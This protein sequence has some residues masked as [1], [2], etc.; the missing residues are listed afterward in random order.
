[1]R[2]LFSLM[3]M[4]L[5]AAAARLM[6]AARPIGLPNCPTRCGDVSVPYPFGI[7]PGCYLPGFN[8]TCDTTYSPPRLLLGNGV[9]QV[10]DI[11]L[12]SSTVHARGPDIHMDTGYHI[13]PVTRFRANGTWG[14]GGW[15]FGDNSPYLLSESHNE[16]IFSGCNVFAE[17][18]LH[19]SNMVITSCGSLCDPSADNLQQLC[20]PLNGRHCNKCSGIG[21]C[22]VPVAIAHA[23]YDVRLVG[24]AN[25]DPTFSVLIAEEGWFHQNITSKTLTTAIPVVLAWVARSNALKEPNRTLQG[26][27]A[28]LDSGHHMCH[29]SYSSCTTVTHVYDDQDNGY[30]CKCWDGY[31]GNPYLPDGCQDID[32]CAPPNNCHGICTNTPG[33]YSCKCPH[34]THGDPHVPDGCFKLHTDKGL[35]IGLGVGSAVALLFL[36]VASMLVFR[37]IKEKRKK[38]LRQRFFKQNRG[39][40]LQQLVSQRTDIA[41]RMIIGL[42]ELEKATNNFDKVRELGSGGHGTVYKGILSSLH[43]VAV[44]KS[45]IVVQQEIDEFISEVAILSQINHRNIVKLME[46]C[47]ETEVP[48]LV[49]EFINNGTLYNHLHVEAPVSLSWKDRLR[50]AVE[51]AGALAYLHSYVSR[52][53]IHRDIK[54]PN[55]L[56]DDNLTVKLSDF[57]ASRHIPADQSGLDTAVQGTFG[58]L[59]PTYYST[60]HLTE[61]SDVYSF[62]VILIELLTRKKPVTYRSNQ[63][64]GLVKHFVTLLSEGNLAHVLD[65]QV[66]REG[67]GE[68]VD[69]AL[70]AKM[71][72]KSVAEERPT[73]RQVEMTLESIYAAKDFVSSDVTEDEFEADVTWEN[74]ISVGGIDVEAAGNFVNGEAHS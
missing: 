13:D 30:T 8:L 58:Y 2:E 28:C 23:S 27:A 57:G 38:K 70:L 29:S 74:G 18:L 11:S 44:K 41:E 48:L 67:A 49:Y 63:G 37:K 17:L 40:L 9:L 32:E 33:S 14:G 21:C 19:G 36:I 51:T 35:A 71:C 45:K 34:G 12:D 25:G 43:V 22:Q 62:G 6:A 61:K 66:S 52:P 73:M 7:Q 50:I 4:L 10:T 53:I 59:D 20:P 56:L 72:V 15:G 42:K 60:G 5:L 54:S 65:P 24:F 39:Q 46:C 55:I 26:N 16:F 68:V 69:I 47:L 31:Q 3:H 64:Y 1:M